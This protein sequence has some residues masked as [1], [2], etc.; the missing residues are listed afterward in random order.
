MDTHVS[1]INTQFQVTHDVHT[2][3]NNNDVKRIQSSDFEHTKALSGS[4]IVNKHC[5]ESRR[6]DANNRHVIL[7][8]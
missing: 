3:T 5:P 7:I 2:V 8:N 4:L 6:T 1:T